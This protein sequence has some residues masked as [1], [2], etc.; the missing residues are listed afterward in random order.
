MGEWDAPHLISYDK[1]V[2]PHID[3]CNIACGGHAGSKRIIALTIELAAKYKVKIGAHPGFE[4]RKKFGRKYIS[5]SSAELTKSLAKQ[6]KA[7][8][9]VCS[10]LNAQAFHI[11][12][13]GALYHACNHMD[14]E[15][16]VFVNVVKKFSP[17]LVILVAPESK[18]EKLARDNGLSTMTESFIDRRYNEDLSLV[19]RS[20]PDAVITD[21]SIAKNQ[22]VALSRGEVIT[23]KGT[24][25]PL[26]S[27]TACIHG[28][29]PKCLDILKAIR[30]HE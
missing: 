27:L 28:D 3:M 25:K 12:A 24:A 7:F 1:E 29:N 16:S 4:D 21:Q 26:K 8:L 9:E 10:K 11:K 6:I 23:I 17:D 13:H 15:A 19:S 14:T 22:F 18:L 20:E 30:N 2:M 5:L